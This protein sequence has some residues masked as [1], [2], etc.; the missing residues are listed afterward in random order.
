MLRHTPHT[1]PLARA[2]KLAIALGLLDGTGLEGCYVVVD[3]FDD[4]A[5]V[6]LLL[7]ALRPL[8][9]DLAAILSE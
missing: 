7:P 3:A 4:V 5:G 9:A 2:F 1:D 6:F 8:P